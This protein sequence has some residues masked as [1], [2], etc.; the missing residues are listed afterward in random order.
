LTSRNPE[1]G[2]NQPPGRDRL[3]E[4]GR[5]SGEL[6]HDLGGA[7]AILSG[8]VA[9]AREEAAMG[10][11]PSEELAHIAADADELRL[12]VRELITDLQGHPRPLEVTFSVRETLEGVVNRWIVG[13]P[14]VEITLDVDVG[15]DAEIQGPRTFFSRAIGNLIRNAAR[16]ARSRI[17]M[18]AHRVDQ[19]RR[20]LVRVIDDGD[21]VPEDVRSQL[22]EPFVSHP[23]NLMNPAGEAGVGLGLS[24][25]RWGI[26]RLGGTLGLEPSPGPL[27]GAAFSAVL[28]LSP[29]SLRQGGRESWTKTRA[30]EPSEL[31]EGLR[32]TFIDD[33]ETLRITFSRLLERC[34]ARVTTP[35][36][37]AWPAP[38]D[39][40][41]TI[42]SSRP[43][44]ILLDISLPRFA[45]L[46]LARCLQ[47]RAPEL[48]DRVIFFTGNVTVDRPQG[49]PVL[50]KVATWDEMIRVITEVHLA[51]PR[52]R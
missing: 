39:A 40:L 28:P 44:V 11:V 4:I 3:L 18:T 51:P 20:V 13:A 9:L 42:H 19:G 6:L 32:V 26:E 38:E 37:D 34:G 48:H 43:D 17:L 2:R 35:D 24:F 25:A 30:T 21:G 12:M 15:P 8:R 1:P 36:P 22:F 52:N 47:S 14:H 50:S 45:G 7:L 46:D 41:H 33:D 10:R 5:I 16:H 27:G 49:R 29:L 31:P 23:G